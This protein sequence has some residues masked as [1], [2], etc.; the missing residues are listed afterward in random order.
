MQTKLC[1]SVL[2]LVGFVVTI[3]MIQSAA[4]E[5]PREKMGLA[6]L[7]TLDKNTVQG[8]VAIFE[9]AL[10]DEEVRRLHTLALAVEPIGK[11]A[12]T[13]GAL[14]QSMSERN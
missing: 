6:A 13:W 2:L 10:S 8:E 1:L 4:A 14:K 9:G 11:L 5:D 7:W 3:T 12:V